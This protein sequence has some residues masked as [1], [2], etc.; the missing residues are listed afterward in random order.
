MDNPNSKRMNG[1]MQMPCFLSYKK[2]FQTYALKTSLNP[3]KGEKAL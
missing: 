1:L 3:A 2:I